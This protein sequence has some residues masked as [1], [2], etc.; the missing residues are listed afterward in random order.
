VILCRYGSDWDHFLQAI[1]FAYRIS[2]IDAI[3]FSPYFL[4]FVHEPT[5]P[6]HILY[7]EKQESDVDMDE[8]ALKHPK[9]MRL[10]FEKRWKCSLNLISRKRDILTRS[11]CL[12]TLKLGDLVWL[13]TPKIKTGLSRKISP[14]NFG[15]YKI[16][17]INKNSPVNYTIANLDG[18]KIG[19]IHSR[20][21]V[22]RLIPFH[23]E[24]NNERK[25]QE[26]EGEEKESFVT[27]KKSGDQ[28]EILRERISEE[29][30]SEFLIQYEN[31]RNWVSHQGV[32]QTRVKIFRRV[33]R[34]ERAERRKPK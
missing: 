13:S 10:A 17:I 11:K 33:S 30:G 16:K 28:G 5:L 4:L 27:P 19:N 20:V 8:Y 32:D 2:F 6:T 3:K 9:M 15:P 14:T 25:S 21:H 22:Q 26:S 18:T 31:S 1:A 29:K 12:W 23:G 7:G 24:V 34:E